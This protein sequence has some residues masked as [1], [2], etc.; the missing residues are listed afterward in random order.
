MSVGGY[1]QH[2]YRMQERMGDL[3]A[4]KRIMLTFL[5]IYLGINAHFANGIV[6]LAFTYGTLRLFLALVIVRL[7]V[8]REG[9][10]WQS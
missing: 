3:L 7:A 6:S 5:G 1:F 4:F 2:L 8:A 10:K 9:L